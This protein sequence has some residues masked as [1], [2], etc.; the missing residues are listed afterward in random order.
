MFNNYYDC[1]ALLCLFLCGRYSSL[2]CYKLDLE[3]TLKVFIYFVSCK[4]DYLY[5]NGLKSVSLVC[6]GAKILWNTTDKRLS[7]NAFTKWCLTVNKIALNRWNANIPCAV[8]AFFIVNFCTL[9]FCKRQLVFA[10]FASPD[11]ALISDWCLVSFVSKAGS[12][13]TAARLSA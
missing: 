10:L 4:Q 1:R 8:C 13:P 9:Q 12:V 2:D 5:I 6:K 7:H 3:L 11:C